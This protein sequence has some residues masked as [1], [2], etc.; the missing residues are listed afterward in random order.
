[1]SMTLPQ[2]IDQLVIMTTQ[3]LELAEFAEAVMALGC[4][5]HSESVQVQELKERWEKLR[6]DHYA[7]HHGGREGG[8]P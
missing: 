6:G 3:R 7:D 1:M 5:K 8:L 4:I 2:A